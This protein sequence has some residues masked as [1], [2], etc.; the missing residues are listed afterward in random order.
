[1]NGLNSLIIEGNLISRE[2]EEN[3][4]KFMVAYNHFYKDENG[5]KRNETS[6]FD[7][8]AYGK[9]ADFCEQQFQKGCGV[10]IVGRLKQKRWTDE[11][12]KHQSRIFI[13]AE[14]VEF[15]FRI[16]K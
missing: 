6:Y 8:E 15:K 14:H 9:L 12:G 3:T 16:S 10:R 5:N 2:R 7:V 13:V 1:M 11:S 4:F